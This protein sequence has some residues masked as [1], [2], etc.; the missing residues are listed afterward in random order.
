MDPDVAQAL[1][2]LLRTTKPQDAASARLLARC[3]DAL[4][5]A[6]TEPEETP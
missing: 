5:A 3:Y 6:D 2:D 4:D 1:R